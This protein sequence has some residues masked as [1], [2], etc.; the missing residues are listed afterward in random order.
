MSNIE[1]Q[2]VVDFSKNMCRK[3]F[4]QNFDKTQVF[5]DIFQDAFLSELKLQIGLRVVSRFKD[6]Y[7]DTKSTYKLQGSDNLPDISESDLT[8]FN[9]DIE[10]YN[11]LQPVPKKKFLKGNSKL[12]N[13]ERLNIFKLSS[14]MS[15]K[16]LASKYN[17]DM[18][19]IRRTINNEKR[20][21]ITL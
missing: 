21:F 17:V 18:S 9:Y 14:T 16:N 5:D 20:K 15:N 12:S 11:K 10:L 7:N 13:V 8:E 6:L 4:G 19:T 2:E 1:Y 3:K